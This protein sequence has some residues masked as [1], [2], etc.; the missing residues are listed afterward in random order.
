[1]TAGPPSEDER[2]ATRDDLRSL[3]R[4]LIVAGVWAVAATAI[5]VIA[6]VESQDDSSDTSAPLDR[7]ASRAQRQLARRIAVLDER[8]DDLATSEDVK[9]LEDRLE[10]VEDDVGNASDDSQR[11]SDQVSALERR[12]K[13]LEGQGQ[14]GGSS[15]GGSTTSP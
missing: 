14:S 4:W 9:R 3:R 1:V 15:S 7:G 2:P 5:A 11:A 12:V 8:L 6:L 10:E 13:K